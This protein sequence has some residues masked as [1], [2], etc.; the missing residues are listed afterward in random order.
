MNVRVT[1]NVPY[2]LVCVEVLQEI[3]GQGEHQ[4]SSDHLISVHVGNQFHHG[5]QSYTFTLS[6]NQQNCMD[7]Y[8]EEPGRR[9]TYFMSFNID[10]VTVTFR[11]IMWISNIPLSPLLIFV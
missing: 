4:F 10:N 6:Q 3:S 8:S 1:D 9:P 5:L 11:V 2:S 7:R